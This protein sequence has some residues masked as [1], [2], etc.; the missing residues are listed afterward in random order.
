MAYRP[1]FDPRVLLPIAG[2]TELPLTS[3]RS[4]SSRSL[5]PAPATA[6]PQSAPPPLPASGANVG[7]HPRVVSVLTTCGYTL[8]QSAAAAAAYPPPSTALLRA[9]PAAAPPQQVPALHASGQPRVFSTAAQDSDTEDEEETSIRRRTT[10]KQMDLSVLPQGGSLRKWVNSLIAE[11]LRC[12]NRSKTRTLKFIQAALAA[13]SPSEV[14]RV[15]PRWDAFDTELSCALAKI[16]KGA[17]GRKVLLHQEQCLRDMRTAT[18]SELLVIIVS[19]YELTY[20]QALQVDMQ[21]LMSL[22]FKGKLEEFL[23][24]LDASLSRMTREPDDALLLT[25]VEPLLRQ[26]PELE[27]DFNIFDRAASDSVRSRR[28]S[29]SLRDEVPSRFQEPHVSASR[30]RESVGRSSHFAGCQELQAA[31]GQ[32]ASPRQPSCRCCRHPWSAASRPPPPSHQ[33]AFDR[34]GVAGSFSASPPWWQACRPTFIIR[35]TVC[36]SCAR[37]CRA[38]VLS[39]RKVKWTL[40]PLSQLLVC[41]D[42]VHQHFSLHDGATW[43]SAQLSPPSLRFCGP[44]FSCTA[45]CLLLLR[46]MRDGFN[47]RFHHMDRAAAVLEQDG[48]LLLGVLHDFPDLAA[49]RATALANVLRCQATRRNPWHATCRPPPW[50]GRSS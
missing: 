43:T 41:G 48:R 12:S 5:A 47:A 6:S 31:S 23:D 33:S 50:L 4:A 25:I 3:A 36:M 8:R 30:P 24:N 20:G 10:P 49:V 16:A 45:H 15:S 2:P 40:S 1:V 38:S 27:M 7:V 13:S 21:T 17:I 9:L 46:G 32:D 44:S 42:C 28:E 19:H 11:A 37:T 34:P 35:L 22:S 18:G 26:A 39:R 14:Q 29:P